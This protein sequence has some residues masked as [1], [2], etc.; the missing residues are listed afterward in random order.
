MGLCE[1]IMVEKLMHIDTLLQAGKE[2]S[3]SGDQVSNVSHLVPTSEGLLYIRT[4]WLGGIFDIIFI[5]IKNE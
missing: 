5:Y 2:T 4:L 1:A 3:S